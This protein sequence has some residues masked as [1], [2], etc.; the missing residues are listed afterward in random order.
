[1]SRAPSGIFLSTKTL[2]LSHRFTL[3]RSSMLFRSHLCPRNIDPPVSSAEL[4]LIEVKIKGSGDLHPIVPLGGIVRRR[5][6]KGF[7]A[8][9]LPDY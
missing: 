1:M 7:L 3:N 6:A 5:S 9:S 4:M 2:V 8:I